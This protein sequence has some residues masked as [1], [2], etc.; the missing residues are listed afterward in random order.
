[1]SL[2]EVVAVVMAVEVVALVV[3]GQALL[4]NLLV[5]AVVLKA[6]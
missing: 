6:H 5:E 3:T 1:L 2:V 4:V